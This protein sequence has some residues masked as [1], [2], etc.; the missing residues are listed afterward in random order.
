MSSVSEAGFGT[1][2]SCALRLNPEMRLVR[3]VLACTYEE[4]HNTRWG[5]LTIFT[6]K[7]SAA[8]QPWG[9]APLTADTMNSLHTTLAA[10]ACFRTLMSLSVQDGL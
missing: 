5:V 1:A 7:A 3:A 9:K 2:L 6:A 10:A 8:C 4:T